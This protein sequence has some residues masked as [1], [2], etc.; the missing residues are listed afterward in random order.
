[1]HPGSARERPARAKEATTRVSLHGAR[2]STTANAF[3]TDFRESIRTVFR[4]MPWLRRIKVSTRGTAPAANWYGA[5]SP[6]PPFSRCTAEAPG[7]RRPPTCAWSTPIYRRLRRPRRVRRTITWFRYR[8]W[9]IRHNGNNKSSVPGSMAPTFRPGTRHSSPVIHGGSSTQPQGE[10]SV[11]FVYD[12]SAHA[13]R[14][15]VCGPVQ[16]GSMSC[17]VSTPPAPSSGRVPR[18]RRAGG[19]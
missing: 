16:T 19:R 5:L 10:Q 2:W 13:R 15:R 12:R 1:M 18:R 7:P 11:R 6:C 9:V 3:A 17:S 8:L 14:R 4:G